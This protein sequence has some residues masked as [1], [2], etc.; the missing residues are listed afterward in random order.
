MHNQTFRATTQFDLRAAAHRYDDV[1][2]RVIGAAS[3]QP[4]V[5]RKYSEPSVVMA[6]ASSGDPGSRAQAIAAQNQA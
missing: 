5:H 6:A 1:I 3:A 2:E 4:P